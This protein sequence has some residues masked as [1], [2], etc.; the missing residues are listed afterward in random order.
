MKRLTKIWRFDILPEAALQHLLSVH[1]LTDVKRYRSKRNHA[2]GMVQDLFQEDAEV[3][4]PAKF[5]TRSIRWC[6]DS[7]ESDGKGFRFSDSITHA[8]LQKGVVKP[9]VEKSQAEQKARVK[10]KA[11][12]F[13]PMW[14]CN[15]QNNLI[16]DHMVGEGLFNNITEDQK[17]W[18]P[19]AS[20]LVFPNPQKFSWVNYLIDR[21]LEMAAG[22][23]PY[24]MS[25]YDATTGSYFPV[26]D[27]AGRYQRIGLLDRKFRV[28]NENA[29]TFSQ[30]KNLAAVAVATT[31][32]YEWQGDNLLLARLNM[33]NTYFDYLQVFLGEKGLPR[34]SKGALAEL[35]VEVSEDVSWQLW[36]MDGLKQVIPNTCSDSCDSCR[37][38]ER[39]G[40]DGELPVVRWGNHVQPFEDFI[41]LNKGS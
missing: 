22:E 20:P 28:V 25:P 10:A 30:W 8:A 31:Y 41:A 4:P 6:T 13:T 19:T 12:V 15:L 14:V 40:H 38:N 9:R 3:R 32:G 18:I 33:L 11:E 36:Q 35:A 26:K 39:A 23:A 1:V 5:T 37:K 29:T 34:L 7:Y 21:R 17:V 27:E 16:D 24:L 2:V